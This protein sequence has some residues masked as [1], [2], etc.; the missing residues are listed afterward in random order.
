M[1]DRNIDPS[2]VAYGVE[3]M[4]R[5]VSQWMKGHGESGNTP[6]PIIA[7]KGYDSVVWNRLYSRDFA[8]LGNFEIKQA[9]LVT[10]TCRVFIQSAAN[11]HVLL[12]ENNHF[13]L[14]FLINL[15]ILGNK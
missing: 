1:S 7:T 11:R 12:R 15:V 2:T 9:S 8:D 13:Q 10:C 6:F 5:E 4:N 14:S 3:R